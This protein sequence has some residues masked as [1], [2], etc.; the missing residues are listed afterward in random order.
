MRID[1]TVAL[2]KSKTVKLKNPVPVHFVYVTAWTNAGGTV[3]FR[4]DLYGRDG[5]EIQ[6]A[7]AEKSAVPGSNAFAP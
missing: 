2:G 3:Q 1:V 6:I 4:N 7:E 5:G